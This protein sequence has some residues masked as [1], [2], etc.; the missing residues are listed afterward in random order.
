MPLP[1]LRLFTPHPGILAWYD[2][3][4]DG[5][6]F[7]ARDN[8][9]DDG[10]LAVGIASFAL[11]ED[12]AAIVY[13]TGTTLAHG[14]AIRAEL[15]RRGVRHIRVVLSHWHK[16]HVAGTAAF[17]AVEVIATARTAAHLATRRA[18][19]EAG[20]KWP[21]IAP[22][23]LPG[24]VFEGRMT[25][26]LGQRRV[27][28]IEYD[29]HSD[30]AAVIWLA[31]S[32]LLLAGDTLEDPLTYLAEPE[33][34]GR[35]LGELA[36]LK[37]LGARH[38][39]PCHGDPAVIAAGGYGPGLIEATETYVRFLL[40]LAGDPGGRG[41]PVTEVLAPH[42]AAGDIRWFEAYAGVHA[43]NLALLEAMG[44]G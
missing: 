17:G 9:V 27:E 23:I 33:G 4:V 12:E 38:I 25:L 24:T 41:R 15:E 8:W 37:A 22:L 36:R 3:R 18:E 35:H 14:E 40:S 1:H 43:E 7:A 44:D 26:T 6:R 31:D 2:G 30:D 19:I 13:D 32:G 16:D 20:V 34:L 42:I 29:I 21:P 10:A 39:L 28:L 5:Y 11:I